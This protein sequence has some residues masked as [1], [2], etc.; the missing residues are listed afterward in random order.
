MAQQTIDKVSRM[1]SR[2]RIL[3]STCLVSLLAGILA[4]GA[5]PEERTSQAVAQPT[6][7]RPLA[8]P[9]NGVMGFVVWSFVNSVIQGKDACPEGTA[10]QNREIFLSSLPPEESERLKKKEN[11]AEFNQRWRASLTRPDGANICS[12]YTQFPERPLVRTV[13][14][15]YA[16]GLDLDGDEGDGSK[17]PD[18]CKHENF[19]TPDGQKGIDNQ[20]YRALGCTLSWRG[21]DGVAGDIQ[22]GF[23]DHQASGEYTQVLLLRGVDSLVN[24]P[25][26]EV[27]YGNTPD[28][29]V[30]DASGKFI[31]NASFTITDQAPR[32]RN[33]L[34]GKIVN[35]VL[36]TEPKLIKLTQT[37]GQSAARDLRG[38]RS[39]WTLYKGRLRLTFQP[40]GTLKGI[41][42]GYQPLDEPI[43]AYLLG[44]LGSAMVAGE[45]CAGDYN[46]L[47]KLADGMRDP[48]TGE[49]TAISSGLELDAVPAFVNDVPPKRT[50][51]QR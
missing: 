29:P 3:R 11:G 21:V 23:R 32:E 37:W 12:Q 25:D 36:T 10:R 31:W 34:K 6:S 50:I 22:R 8:P 9:A 7:N 46:T 5:A 40:D 42:G 27:I 49:C 41:V 18:G 20:S 48:K 17:D 44:G 26:V 39:R 19:T 47:K 38:I 24:D 4:L 30:V 45:D 35:G 16:W 15:K 2:T 1:R 51:A 13:Q 28:R 43:K 14:S 33:V